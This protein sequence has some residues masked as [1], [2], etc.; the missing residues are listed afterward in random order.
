MGHTASCPQG[1]FRAHSALLALWLSSG[2]LGVWAPV[3]TCSDTSLTGCVRVK[4]AIL[5][6]HPDKAWRLVGLRAHYQE[7]FPVIIITMC[8]PTLVSMTMVTMVN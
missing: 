8:L 2:V 1:S 4:Q 7:P 3:L 6:E 5:T